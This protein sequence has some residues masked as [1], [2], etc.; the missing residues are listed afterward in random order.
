MAQGRR[1]LRTVW[2]LANKPEHLH[3][4]RMRFVRLIDVT[5]SVMDSE[6]QLI[7]RC[8]DGDK[9]ALRRL[10]ELHQEHVYRVAFAIS[11]DRT[12]A[13]DVTQE[14][15]L[16]AWRALPRF[17]GDASLKTWLTRLAVN[18]ACDH[19]RKQRRW[20]AFHCKIGPLRPA[21]D[22]ALCRIE[23]DDEVRYALR[24]LSPQLRE[25]VALRY[26]LD[27]SPREI[28]DVVHCPEGT[29]KS[30]LHTALRLLRNVLQS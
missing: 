3:E 11:A 5:V 12:D 4:P 17:R 25:V 7:A 27:M 18:T 15:F 28:A 9:E 20:L 24:Q 22:D 29:V 1:G 30:R 16:K 8:R 2:V 6:A 13:G 21:S 19:L 23:D 10:V 14:T 26:G